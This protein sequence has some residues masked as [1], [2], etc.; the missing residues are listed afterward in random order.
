MCFLSYLIKLLDILLDHIIEFK[1][2][3]VV[4]T[5]YDAVKISDQ[6]VYRLDLYQEPSQE[7]LLVKPHIYPSRLVL[8]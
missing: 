2:L 5:Y 8:I 3:L 6:L 1:N 7:S 4:L